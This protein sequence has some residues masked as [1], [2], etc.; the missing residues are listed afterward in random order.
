MQAVILAGGMGQRLRPMTN[1]IPKPLMPI[2]EKAIIE[3]QIEYLKKY[4]FD[5]IY[6]STNYKSD[7]ISKFLGDGLR[8]GVKLHIYKEDVKLGTAGPIRMLEKELLEPFLVINSDIIS[9]L[10][11]L[12]FYHYA[13]NK[14]EIMTMGVKKVEI[15]TPY[16]NVYSSDGRV[17]ALKEKQNIVIYAMS[18]LYILKPDI[19]KYIPKNTYYGMDQLI[20][21]LLDMNIDIATYEI[22]EY[23]MDIGKYADY[24]RV[25]KDYIKMKEDKDE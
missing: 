1:V 25:Q 2:G 3:L 24:E 4:G 17:V 5:E 13:S 12:Y 14:T 7:Y 10:D 21:N 22:N 23:W 20:N 9:D 19:I 15:P 6:V 11:L 16:G 8:Y 18:G